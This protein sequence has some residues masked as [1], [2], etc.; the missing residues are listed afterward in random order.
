MPRK[1]HHSFSE[2]FK[3]SRL[4]SYARKFE[5]GGKETYRI[6]CLDQAD[7]QAVNELGLRITTER[8]NGRY[9]KI[10]FSSED[11]AL[12]SEKQIEINKLAQ[13]IRDKQNVDPLE[14]KE[15]KQAAHIQ[16]QAD[17]NA[18]RLKKSLRSNY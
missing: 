15:M 8:L 3:M 16:H 14:I 4:K 12:A 1:G 10:A 11:K 5:K 13:S 7:I 9:L 2:G 6:I 17:L 18:Y